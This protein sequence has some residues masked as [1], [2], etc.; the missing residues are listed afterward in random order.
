LPVGVKVTDLRQGVMKMSMDAEAISK[1]IEAELVAYGDV[2]IVTFIR[3]YLVGPR[4]ITLAWDYGWN[5]ETMQPADVTYP[6][7][8]VLEDLIAGAKV[9]YCEHGFGPSCPWGL[10]SPDSEIPSM[11]MDSGWFTS[12]LSAFFDSF[13]STRL[14]IYE[15]F[16]ATSKG[17][18]EP[19]DASAREGSWDA[20]WAKI[21]R[22]RQSAVPGSF[23]AF[24]RRYK[25]W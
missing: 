24:T 21:E 22:L 9:V 10:V 16:I 3:Q 2:E 23:C 7:W 14:N 13:S 5:S 20:A 12:F 6:A 1:L 17:G 8:S 18:Y 25:Q 4:P 11:G 19:F 15:V